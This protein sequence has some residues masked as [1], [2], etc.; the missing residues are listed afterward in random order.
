MRGR[1]ADSVQAERG[2]QQVPT[3]AA[4]EAVVAA[5]E[6]VTKRFGAVVALHRVN[7]ACHRGEILALVGENGAG[8]STLLRILAGVFP[9]DAGTVRLRVT[10]AEGGPGEAAVPRPGRPGPGLPRH[11]PPPPGLLQTVRFSGPQHATAL[12]IAMV[13]QELSLV[14]SLTVAENLVLGRE[15]TGPFGLLPFRREIAQ[16]AAVLR[17]LGLLEIDPAAEVA[18]LSPAARQLVEVAKAWSRRPRLLIL[19]EP[20]SGLAVAEVERLLGILSDLRRRGVAIIFVSHR[21]DEVFAVS[22][23]IVVMKDGEVVASHA[24]GTVSRD[25]V[26]REMVG[27]PLGQAFA[28]RRTPPDGDGSQAATVPVLEMRGGGDGARF[29]GIDLALHPGEIVGIGGLEGHGQREV[30]RALFGLH[31]LRAGEIRVMGRPVVLRGPADAVRHG[32]ALVPEDRREEG[33]ILPLTVRENLVLAYLRRLHRWGIIRGRLE[34][35]QVREGMERLRIRADTP[36]APMRSLSGG[37]QQKVIFARWLMT[38]PRVLLLHEPT[39]GIDVQTKVEIYHLLR[40]LADQGLA[41]GL[42]SSDMV[43]LVGL[44][45][46]VVVLREGRMAG[47]VSGDGIGEEAIMRLA[48]G[49]ALQPAAGT[50]RAERGVRG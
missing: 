14:P 38:R 17:E 30:I 10:P 28:R 32:I 46:R 26:V 45:D 3:D 13:H 1:R 24:P 2:A 37:N 43:E 23:R 33:L 41:V 7:L 27:R 5:V 42:V 47:A 39:R 50:G 36:D 8:K 11:G 34:A 18:S 19:D 20:T 29:A 40:S 48:S 25:E 49:L 12:G 6:G 21:L 15:D 35:G 31:R 44:C 16:G 4:D 9:P 22:D